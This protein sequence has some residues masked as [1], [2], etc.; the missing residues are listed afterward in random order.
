MA[1][2]LAGGHAIPEIVKVM[3]RSQE[4]VRNRATTAGLMKRRKFQTRDE[5]NRVH[6]VR[7]EG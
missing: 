6:C 5:L 7:E 2:M 3:G 1:D 4:A